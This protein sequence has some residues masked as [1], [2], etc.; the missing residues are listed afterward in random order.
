MCF[1]HLCHFLLS[2]EG[3]ATLLRCSTGYWEARRNR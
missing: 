3:L 2:G 1:F